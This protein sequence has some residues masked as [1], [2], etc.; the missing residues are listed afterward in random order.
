MNGKKNSFLSKVTGF[1]GGGGFYIAL[2]L[3]VAMIGIYAWVL[4]ANGYSAMKTPEE[5]ETTV[6]VGSFGTGSILAG[7]YETAAPRNRKEAEPE[8]EDRETAAPLESEEARPV[9][10][11]EEGEA[12]AVSASQSE[13]PTFFVWPVPG[14][15]T[16]DYAVEAL[17]YDVTMS[18]WRTHAAMDLQAE[19]GSKVYA[20][21]DGKVESIVQDPLLG[22]VVSLSH[23]GGLKSIYAN[24]GTEPTVN[25]GD[26]VS[27]GTVIGC[28]SDSALGE[29][30]QVSH[31]HFAMEKDGV[32]VDPAAWL[33]EK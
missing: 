25:V 32:R 3:C 20:V 15:I 30:A 24:L 28:V 2:F 13:T 4:L 31:L 21:A 17:G 12:V 5:T 11:G 10:A 1:F 29:I 18:D 7:D 22:T 6:P 9:S 16:R 19:L 14:E 33:P 26:S 27:A 8:P 23:A